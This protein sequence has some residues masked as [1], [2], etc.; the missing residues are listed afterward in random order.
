[1]ALTFNGSNNTIG[2]V[3]V[4]GLPDGCV[5]TDMLAAN[6]VTASKRGTHGILQVVSAVSTTGASSTAEAAAD[7]A[8]SCSITTT[9]NSSKVYVIV[10]QSMMVRLTGGNGWAVINYDLLRDSQVLMNG[11]DNIAHR[12]DSHSPYILVAAM[13]NCNFLDTPGN[14]GTYTYK[15]QAGR[16]AS[17]GS[18]MNW[19][20]QDNSS[21]ST[22]T[23]LEIAG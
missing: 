21:P 4:G 12:G 6:A 19:K 13:V 16:G 11:V 22:M 3:A 7:T 20:A 2:G 5:D 18:S 8:L 10:S 15:T 17:G 9:T 23:L 14:A 1:M